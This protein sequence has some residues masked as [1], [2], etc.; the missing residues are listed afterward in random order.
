MIQYDWSRPLTRLFWAAFFSL[1]V[2]L[3]TYTGGRFSGI[4]QVCNGDWHD[5]LR[6]VLRLIGACVLVEL[7]YWAVWRGRHRSE[8]SSAQS[9]I[10]VAD[11]YVL[12]RDGFIAPKGKIWA[13][14]LGFCLMQIGFAI[15]PDTC[16][17][18]GLSSFSW[19]SGA[20][21][22]TSAYGLLVWGEVSPPN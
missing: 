21:I 10:R 20:G 13:I 19:T 18:L 15:G 14:V 4:P 8:S 6:T 7:G 17:Q 22:L 2:V 12:D 5:A 1:A 3:T 9:I 16:T 11:D